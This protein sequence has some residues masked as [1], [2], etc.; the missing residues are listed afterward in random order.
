MK[1]KGLRNASST[2]RFACFRNHLHERPLR[3]AIHTSSPT[4]HHTRTHPRV[5]T[6]NPIRRASAAVCGVSV[7]Y[8]AEMKLHAD[9]SPPSEAQEFGSLMKKSCLPSR[10]GPDRVLLKSLSSAGAPE[11]RVQAPGAGEGHGVS[12][13]YITTQ[14]S[15][16]WLKVNG[17][18]TRAVGEKPEWARGRRAWLVRP[19]FTGQKFGF[20]FGKW[21]MNQSSVLV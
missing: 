1:Q 6:W 8:D 20:L 13:A 2:D 5:R 17:R 14:N 7:S 18:R 3:D 21:R 15:F 11:R 19:V 16:N 9:K 4:R 10:E 12:V